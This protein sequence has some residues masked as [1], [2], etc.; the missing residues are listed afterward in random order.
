MFSALAKQD[1]TATA[2]L[3]NNATSFLFDE[4]RYELNSI[5]ID[6]TKNVGYTTTL[7]NYVS[8]SNDEIKMLYNSSWNMDADST[9]LVENG[10][11]NFCVPLKLLLGFAEDYNKII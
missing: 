1:G 10:R 11:F 3:V 2:R 6:R 5:E 4:V 9:I 7:K 8:R